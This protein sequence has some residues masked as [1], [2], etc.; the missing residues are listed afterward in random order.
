M[1]G[2]ILVSLLGLSAW[3]VGAGL[4]AH[5]R[6]RAAQRL[7][8]QICAEREPL[9]CAASGGS[10]CQIET[11]N[12]SRSARRPFVVEVSAGRVGVYPLGGASPAWVARPDDLR[13][14]GRPQK[15][16][17]GTNEIWLHA[18]IAGEWHLIKLRL[19]A[20]HMRGL[21]RALK[22]IATE[23]QVTAYRRRRPYIHYGPAA[24][25]PATQDMLGAWTLGAPLHLYLMPLSLVLLKG[26]RVQRVMPL[27]QVQAIS[28]ID[29]LDAP[30][31]PGLVRFQVGDKA[32]AFSVAD[33]QRFASLLGEAARR[34]LED[35]VLWQRK[36]KKPDE[37]DEWDE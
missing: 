6:S 3:S 11:I 5:R 16:H 22:A 32:L 26:S 12:G 14:F 20:T 18:E 23:E 19:S 17:Y 24:A 10:W 27:A 1:S 29:R 33:H 25:R 4:R 21:V 15:Y 13:W 30:G 7:M 35:P 31:E 36:K 37:A 34:T 8:A 9:F 28:A 2:V